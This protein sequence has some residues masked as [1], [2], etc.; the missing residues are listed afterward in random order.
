MHMPLLSVY[1][2]SYKTV[3]SI[4]LIDHC[5]AFLPSIPLMRAVASPKTL[6]TE[7]TNHSRCGG[8]P[9]PV[10][11]CRASAVSTPADRRAF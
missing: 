9:P 4:M 7:S 1:A 5:I 11:G 8:G 3:V 6:R 10:R 2:I